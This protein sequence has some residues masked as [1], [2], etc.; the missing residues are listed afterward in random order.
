MIVSFNSREE[1]VAVRSS[2]TVVLLPVC[3][4]GE[5][6][7]QPGLPVWLIHPGDPAMPASDSS[8]AAVHVSSA[9]L[10]GLNTTPANMFMLLACSRF[11]AH[12]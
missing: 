11:T 7:R 1:A 12:Q 10:Q 4:S 3:T 5:G 2:S 9:G 6:D 8:A